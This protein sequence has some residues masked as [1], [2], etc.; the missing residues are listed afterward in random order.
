[1]N[2]AEANVVLAK[3][4]AYD[5]RRPDPQAA[6][7]WAQ[8]L[9]DIRVEDA[10]EAVVAHYSQSEE[11]M[12]PAHV[13]R[14]VSRMRARRIAAIAEPTLPADLPPAEYAAALRE[15]RRQ[16]GDG[17][18]PEVAAVVAAVHHRALT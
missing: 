9:A 2:V 17:G 3:A 1:M 11:W 8:A 12:R 18:R 4:A 13:R 15:W 16:V 7:A 5:N 6:I 10:V 14:I